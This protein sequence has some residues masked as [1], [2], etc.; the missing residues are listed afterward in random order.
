VLVELLN[1]ELTRQLARFAIGFDRSHERFVVER[2]GDGSRMVRTGSGRPRTIL[3]APDKGKTGFWVHQAARLSFDFIGP[4]LVL[5]VDP[6]LHFTSDGWKHAPRE[7]VP[8]LQAQWSG[9][10]RNRAILGSILLW[11]DLLTQGQRRAWIPQL[12]LGFELRRLPLLAR[13]PR[14]I[15]GDHVD[16][17]VVREFVATEIGSGDTSAAFSFLENASSSDLD[18]AED[19]TYD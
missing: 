8:R 17:K 3:R 5:V 6:A 11:V 12:N 7:M 15:P 16:I 2:K 9:R 18:A 19:W 1:L 13:S 14:S 10:E 4:L